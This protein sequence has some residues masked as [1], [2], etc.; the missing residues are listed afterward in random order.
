MTNQ[1]TLYARA[2]FLL[3]LVAVGGSLYFSEIAGFP[4]CKLCWIQRLAVFPA[5]ILL[6]VG[7]I[8][9]DSMLHT[10]L[11]PLLIPALF[12]SAYHNLLYYNV[13]AE[14]KATCEAG[15]SCTTKYIEWFG[16]LTIP[17]LALLGITGLT[18]LM[19]LFRKEGKQA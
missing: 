18:V 9:K 1:Q 15:I 7:I 14:S 17:L 4:P 5:L 16:F 13:F 12:V 6:A 2:A 11:L 3:T 8:R 10:Y 19:I